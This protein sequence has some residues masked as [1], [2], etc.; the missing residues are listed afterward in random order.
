MRIAIFC[1][2]IDWFQPFVDAVDFE[3]KTLIKPSPQSFNL[4]H[5]VFCLKNIQQLPKINF[6]CCNKSLDFLAIAFAWSRQSFAFIARLKSPYFSIAVLEKSWIVRI[7]RLFLMKQYLILQLSMT[8]R[9][10]LKRFG[11]LRSV[12]LA[13]CFRVA[14]ENIATVWLI[15]L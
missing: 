11:S 4:V 10:L 7:V 6:F 2:W 9:Q 5:S 1:P 13:L 3:S 12:L 14:V 15:V 8:L